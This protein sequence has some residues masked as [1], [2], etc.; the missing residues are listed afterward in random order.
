[1]SFQQAFFD[2]LE[3]LATIQSIKTGVPSLLR[4]A[5]A[6]TRSKLGAVGRGALRSTMPKLAADKGTRPLLEGLV[7]GSRASV[8]RPQQTVVDPSKAAMSTD[9]PKRPGGGFSPP[10]RSRPTILPR[11]GGGQAGR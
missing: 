6:A 5:A 4:G 8:I 10:L 11:A 1:M 3:K 7:G 2:E 9:V